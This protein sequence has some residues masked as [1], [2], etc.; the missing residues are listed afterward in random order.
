MGFDLLSGKGTKYKERD[1]SFLNEIVRNRHKNVHASSDSNE[2][3][4]QNK[5][6]LSNYEQE[7][8][9]LLKILEYLDSITYDLERGQFTD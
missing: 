9:G 8:K 7:Y 6:D 2:W 3:Y 4:N 5:K 1:I